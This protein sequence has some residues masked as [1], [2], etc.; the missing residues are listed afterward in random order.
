MMRDRAI[1]IPQVSQE[2]IAFREA[3][4]DE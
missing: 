2:F 4:V 1:S 3:L